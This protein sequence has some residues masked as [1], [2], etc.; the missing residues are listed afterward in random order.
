MM[1]LFEQDT[2]EEAISRIDI[3]PTCLHAAVRKNGCRADDGAL[4]LHDGDGLGE[5]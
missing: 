5:R 2:V 4:F 1:N 3:L